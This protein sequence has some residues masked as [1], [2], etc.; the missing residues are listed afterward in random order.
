MCAGANTRVH[1]CLGCSQRKQLRP[2]SI[3]RGLS[4]ACDSSTEQR[5]C[6]GVALAAA[7]SQLPFVLA[8]DK[9]HLNNHSLPHSHPAI[10]PSLPP[11]LMQ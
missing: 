4:T 6:R 10:A 2:V 5:R 11:P 1:A 8:A 7:S 3:Q 9:E